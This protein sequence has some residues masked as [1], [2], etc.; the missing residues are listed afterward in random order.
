MSVSDTVRLPG[1]GRPVRLLRDR[2]GIPH[3]LAESRQDAYRGL[4]YSMARDRLWQM[5]LMRRLG[6]GRV[7]EVLGG[8]FVAV[9]AIAR[10]VGLP[11]AAEAAARELSGEAAVLLQAFA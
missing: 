8:P 3:L 10:T 2:H 9:D 6:A 5:D 1:L 11:V 4:G 7:A